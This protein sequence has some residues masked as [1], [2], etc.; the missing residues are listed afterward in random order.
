[1]LYFSLG[2]PK[3]VVPTLRE[4]LAHIS[5]ESGFLFKATV[6]DDTTIFFAPAL[7]LIQA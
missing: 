7:E 1:M 3:N 6:K 2:K 5:N 4:L